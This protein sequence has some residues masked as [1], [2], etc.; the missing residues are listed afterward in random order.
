ML[1]GFFRA[2]SLFLS[3]ATAVIFI[4][5][6]AVQASKILPENDLGAD[7]RAQAAAV[8]VPANG[9][10]I[11]I[12]PNSPADTVRAFYRN[13]REGRIRAAIYLTNL[14]PAI[15]G[16]SDLELKE[17]QVDFEA[18]GKVVPPEIEINGEIISGS[19]ATVTAKLPNEDLDKTEFQ[20]IRLR[21]D[22]GVWVILTVDESAEKRIRREGRNYF[23]NLRMEIHEDD[24]RE[25]LN[26]IAKAQIAYAAQNKGLYGEVQ[27]LISAGFL[28]ADVKS[29]ESTGYNYSITVSADGKKYSAAAVPAVY[30]KTGRRSFSID[31]DERGMPRLVSRDAGAAARAK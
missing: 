19:N 17:F 29:S 1:C 7:S 15:E 21:N 22:G 3:T 31:L 6:C 12:T 4:G 9:S 5:G 14:R 11:K 13:L 8:N 2:Q 28:P 16:L 18:I 23:F 27:A 30:G 26:R 24:A 10:T 25:M 20:Q